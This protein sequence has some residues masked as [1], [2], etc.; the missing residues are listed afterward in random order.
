MYI[1]LGQ[2]AR[3]TKYAG[4]PAKVAAEHLLPLR[5]TFQV[6][7]AVLPWRACLCHAPLEWNA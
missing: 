7:R 5:D 2:V 4:I 1:T 6:E 3:P